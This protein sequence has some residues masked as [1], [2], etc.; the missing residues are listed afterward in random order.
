MASPHHRLKYL[1]MP[2]GKKAANNI[3]NKLFAT[4]G[5]INYLYTNIMSE[6][7]SMPHSMP[8]NILPFNIH[9]T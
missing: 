2:T 9:L 6:W 7:H 3:S 8:L 1:R 4:V 5:R